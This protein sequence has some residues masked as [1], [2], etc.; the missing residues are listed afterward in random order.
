MALIVAIFA[1][2]DTL[3][4]RTGTLKVSLATQVLLGWSA[5]HDFCS[6]VGHGG[7]VFPRYGACG[8]AVHHLLGIIEAISV[9]IGDEVGVCINVVGVKGIAEGE[10]RD[11][12]AADVPFL[13]ALEVGDFKAGELPWETGESG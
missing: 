6:T 2:C 10:S 7:C 9:G 12:V 13:F 5:S 1:N 3:K 11:I 8:H 4:T